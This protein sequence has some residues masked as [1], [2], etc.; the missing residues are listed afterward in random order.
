[1]LPPENGT[2]PVPALTP[3]DVRMIQATF[4]TDVSNQN[5]VYTPSRRYHLWGRYWNIFLLAS[6]ILGFLILW[7]KAVPIRGSA[8]LVVWSFLLLTATCLGAGEAV[9]R[10]LHPFSFTG[11]AVAAAILETSLVR[12]QA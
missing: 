1:M 3:S 8:P 12:R 7:S 6:P 2:G 5:T 9:Y 10:Y 11:L 4:G